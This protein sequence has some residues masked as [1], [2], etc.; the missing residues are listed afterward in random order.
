MFHKIFYEDIINY[1]Y[2][3]APVESLKPSFVQ[4][5]ASVHT[6]IQEAEDTVMNITPPMH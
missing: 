3:V 1:A 5:V 6:Y 4:V 2:P